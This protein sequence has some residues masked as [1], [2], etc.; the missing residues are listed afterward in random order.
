MGCMLLGH[1]VSVTPFFILQPRD[2]VLCNLRMASESSE[3]RGDSTVS[4]IF[5]MYAEKEG[6][7]GGGVSR[8][9]ERSRFVFPTCFALWS[10]TH[11]L[12]KGCCHL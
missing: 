6:E 4:W 1:R 8:T 2:R 3:A 5:A 11:D 9:K 10:M 12:V 7:E